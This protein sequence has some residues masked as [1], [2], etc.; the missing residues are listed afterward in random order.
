MA[1]RHFF[2]VSQW[3][4]PTAEHYAQLQGYANRDRTHPYE[5]L[6]RDYEELRRDYE[7]LRRPFT[8]TAEEPYSDVLR[9]NTS[10][11]EGT[12]HP[13]QKPVALLTFLVRATSTPDALIC[14]PFMGS[15]TTGIACIRTGRR[16][17]GIE[18]DEGYC[19]IARKRME[20]ELK[21]PRLPFQGAP[22]TQC[23]LFSQEPTL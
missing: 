9:F 15:G 7:E 2:S 23:P 13:A 12:F 5:Y 4:L 6:R 17:V 18:I 20:D 8:L 11:T 10:A 1:G 22:P 16:F 14:D 21:Q 3:Q 19:K